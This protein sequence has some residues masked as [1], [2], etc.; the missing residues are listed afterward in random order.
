MS[1]KSETELLKDIGEYRYG[2]SDPE[3]YVFKSSRGLS[4]EVV[5]QI[6]QMK[7]EPQWMLDFRLRALD[8]FQKRPMPTWGSDLSK[9]DFDN[10]FYYVKPTSSEG[11]SG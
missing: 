11:K 6:S 9:L 3:T 1:D 5:E 2:F 10:I 7:G 8:H 4:R